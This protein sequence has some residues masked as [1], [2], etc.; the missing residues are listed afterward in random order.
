[1]TQQEQLTILTARVDKLQE[2]LELL[3]QK[4]IES[5]EYDHEFVENLE[6]LV[7]NTPRPEY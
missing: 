1:M 5:M 7:R 4:T 3:Q 2:A 6:R